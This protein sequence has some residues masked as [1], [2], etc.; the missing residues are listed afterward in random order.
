MRAITENQRRCE[1][2]AVSSSVTPSAKYSCAGSPVMLAKGSTTSMGR[3]AGEDAFADSSRWSRG[4]SEAAG[5][6]TT[7][8]ASL[9]TRE[10]SVA[11]R[12]PRRGTVRSSRCSSSCSAR[13]ISM[14]HWV[15]LSSV[16]MTPGQT[17]AMISSL[18][19]SRPAFSTSWRSSA[20]ALGRSA[21]SVPPAASSAPRT[22]SSVKLSKR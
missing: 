16:T 12:K 20:K 3:L 10:T 1:S 8:V 4:P 13:L 21:T 6:R 9:S 5:W 19:I 2:A 14:T 11:N 18:L 15:M 7:S 17:A 22:M